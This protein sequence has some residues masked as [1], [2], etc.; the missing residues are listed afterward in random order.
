MKHK[1]PYWIKVK[2]N[3]GWNDFK[4]LFDFTWKKRY[5][6]QSAMRDALANMMKKNHKIIAT[7]Y[8]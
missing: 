1:K 8:K 4:G 3:Y 2:Y 6:T 5:K 7:G